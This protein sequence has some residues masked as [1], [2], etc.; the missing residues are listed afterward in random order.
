MGN[1]LVGQIFDKFKSFRSDKTIIKIWNKKDLSIILAV[2][3]PKE[4]EME[5]DPYY[6]YSKGKI[7]GIS[8][9]DNESLVSKITKP[10]FLIYK[11]KSL[12]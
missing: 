2:K 1:D 9:I 3:N 10:E 12:E 5:M 8:Y 6:V 4:W 11:D 7:D